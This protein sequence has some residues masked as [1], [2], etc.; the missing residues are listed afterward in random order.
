M[1]FL[2]SHHGVK[3]T[4]QIR[5]WARQSKW[6]LGLWKLREPRDCSDV[7]S[8]KKTRHLRSGAWN[9]NYVSFQ[10]VS[11]GATW[12]WKEKD[13][14]NYYVV[15][16][17]SQLGEFLSWFCADGRDFTSLKGK[18]PFSWCDK[19]VWGNGPALGYFMLF[20]L[21]WVQRGLHIA[22]WSACI[23][24]FVVRFSRCWIWAGWHL[25]T[26]GW[27][28][29]TCAVVDVLFM[30]KSRGCL[31][32]Q[33]VVT[34]FC[35]MPEFPCWTLGWNI[36][37]FLETVQMFWYGKLSKHAGEGKT[38]ERCHPFGSRDDWPWRSGRYCILW[39]CPKCYERLGGGESGNRKS[40]E[41]SLLGMPSDSVCWSVW[42]VPQS[43]SMV[44][45]P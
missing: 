19:F 9:V 8:R 6:Q 16:C 13:P 10:I 5:D 37:M 24:K 38:L 29:T 26:Q 31:P 17:S 25:P 1:N 22:L 12:T 41:N 3:G 45:D 34:P 35:T 2:H 44:Q 32:A 43:V 39:N 7:S 21:S 14:A 27:H 40:L 4:A 28:M 15:H 42:F 23:C 18:L 33:C 11:K 30:L 36:W 20:R